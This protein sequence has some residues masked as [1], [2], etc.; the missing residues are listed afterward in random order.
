[1]G[2]AKS[3]RLEPNFNRSVK[4]EFDDERVTSNAGVI[5][6]RE[7]DDKL[8]I[9]HAVA[10]KMCDPRRQDRIRYPLAELI[11]ERVYAM[12]TGFS[13]QDDVDRLAHDPAFRVAVW[14]RPGDQVIDERLASQPTQSRLIDMLAN[15]KQN[16][17]ALRDSL[18]DSL[19]RYILTSGKG[20]RVNRG[21]ID[22]DSFPIEVHGKQQG[23]N[24]NGYYQTTTY[25]PLVA[26][27]S[28]G[29][30]YDSSREGMRLGNG[31]LHAILRQ[32]SVHTADGA[33]RFI[34]NAAAKG[35]Q[36]ARTVDF[37]LDAGYTIGTVMD[38]MVNENHKFVGRLKTNA[39]VEKLAAPHLVRPAGRPPREGY[40]FTVELGKY[41]ADK[42]QHAQRLILVVVDRPDPKTGQLSLEPNYFFLVT[43]WPSEKRSA[44]SLLSH[45]R[46]RGTFE[47]RLG[48]FNQA[49]GIH[50]S[51]NEFES[52]EATMLLAMLAFNLASLG[53]IELEDGL[54]GCWDLTRFQL[55]VLK[56]GARVVKRARRLVM[57]VASSVQRFWSLLSGR[58]SRW[59]LPSE[60]RIDRTRRQRLRPAPAH[61]HLEEVLRD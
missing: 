2:E 59:Q 34:R 58:I 33:K 32:G 35:E 28:V 46:R 13:A 14:D 55:Y 29:G 26:S 4:V 53:R 11:R 60:F 9:T 10:Q 18:S 31:F 21:T 5:L 3:N 52:N 57:H 30:D 25:H 43:N 54:G 40:E 15:S 19:R 37:R 41:Q 27:F 49:I 36:L 47:D 44:D 38:A 22:I 39:R 1:M 6:L 8:D 51:S 42:W 24:Y 56:A 45:Y 61:A 17:N 48:E 16:Q 7:L 20:R 23:S 12:A 50:L